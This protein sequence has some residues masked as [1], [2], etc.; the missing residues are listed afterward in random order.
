MAYV[1]NTSIIVGTLGAH[2]RCITTMA[3]TLIKL[4]QQKKR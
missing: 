3:A 4:Y 2:Q 1:D